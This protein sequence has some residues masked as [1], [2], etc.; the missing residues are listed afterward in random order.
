MSIKGGDQVWVC[1]GGPKLQNND[2]NKLTLKIS[3]API[4]KNMLGIIQ[5]G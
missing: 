1:N 5:K 4:V 2:D 3:K